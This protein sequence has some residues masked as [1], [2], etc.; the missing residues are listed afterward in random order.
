M[1]VLCQL[2][3]EKCSFSTGSLRSTALGN[4]WDAIDDHFQLR[5]EQVTSLKWVSR[6]EYQR[7]T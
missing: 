3:G 1:L 6:T 4:V 5:R 2:K 7:K